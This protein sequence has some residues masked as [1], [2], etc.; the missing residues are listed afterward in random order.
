[1]KKMLLIGLFTLP[2]PA[3]AEH[4]DVIQ[5][6]LQDGCTLESYM[7]IVNDF[8]AW[9]EAYGYQTRIAVPLHSPNLESMYWLGTSE[10][11]ATFGK[12]WDTWRNALSDP[13]SGPA[14]LSARLASCMVNLSRD[15]Y[16]IY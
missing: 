5:F 9:G 11:A 3:F 12:A 7:A 10:D 13:D 2:L 14:Q 16:D 15:S 4:M 6:K 8:N 1:M